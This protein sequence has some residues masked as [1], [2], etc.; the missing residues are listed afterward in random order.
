MKKLFVTGLLTAGL[1]FAGGA[2]LR[3]GAE[4]ARG[5]D[6]A[7]VSEELPL[8]EQQIGDSWK[9][10]AGEAAD[11]GYTWLAMENERLAFYVNEGGNIG[12]YD[13]AG[14]AWFTSI[15][16]EEEREA[17]ETAKAINKVNLGS[18]YQ[19]VFVD[20][21]GAVSVKNTLAG[22][23]NDGNVRL[24]DTGE[25]MKVW[26]YI[27]DTDV[28][29]S[30]LYELT[31]DGFTVTVPFEDFKEHIQEGRT[32]ADRG[33]VSYWGIRDISILPYFGAAGPEDEGYM[34]IPDGSG[35]LIEFNYQKSS[36]GA[37]SHDVYG[38]YPVLVL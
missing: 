12:V 16:T 19:L 10:A 24:V 8:P 27:E 36:Y 5:T 25:G 37:Y 17:D 4:E 13:K 26:Y 20:Q 11:R 31:D 21:N 29:F 1:L 7:P 15:P 14:S 18:D 35:A 6:A 28:S 33:T 23:V 2:V 34:L 9:K 38:R 30:V 3:A 32:A 22:A